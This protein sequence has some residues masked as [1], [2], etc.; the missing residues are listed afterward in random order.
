M[1]NLWASKLKNGMK[2]IYITSLYMMCLFYLCFDVKYIWFTFK[3][4]LYNYHDVILH[5]TMQFYCYK[6]PHS[7]KSFKKMTHLFEYLKYLNMYK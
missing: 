6:H 2:N 3:M 4:N 7:H 5:K 1:Q